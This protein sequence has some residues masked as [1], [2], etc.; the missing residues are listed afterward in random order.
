VTCL[1]FKEVVSAYALGAL[2]DEERAACD[3]HL[4]HEGPHEGCEQSLRRARRVSDNLGVA[5]RPVTP[6]EA[7]WDT[8]GER[9]DDAQSDEKRPDRP[10]S[11]RTR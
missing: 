5:L 3:A 11:G 8:I 6:R 10:P 1:E 7:V 9:L 2:D 4:A